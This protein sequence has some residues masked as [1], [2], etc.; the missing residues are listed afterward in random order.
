MLYIFQYINKIKKK[1]VFKRIKK[2]KK[3]YYLAIF[4][5]KVKDRTKLLVNTNF[6]MIA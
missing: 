1:K 2:F 4:T 3:N 6:L 5:L